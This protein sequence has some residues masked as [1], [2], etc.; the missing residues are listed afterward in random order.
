MT[1][2][3]DKHRRFV[4][5]KV[6]G[7]VGSNSITHHYRF[8]YHYPLY[9]RSY[10]PFSQSQYL[11]HYTRYTLY[12]MYTLFLDQKVTLRLYIS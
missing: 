3:D 1:R 8:L 2:E 4:R 10:S 7:E 5:L 12:F 6:D 9:H 11:M